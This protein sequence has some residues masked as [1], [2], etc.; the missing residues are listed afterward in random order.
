M[1]DARY[2]AA[3]NLILETLVVPPFGENTYLIGDAD[4]GVAIA[5]DPGGRADEL[6]ATAERRGVRIEHIINTHAHIDHVSGVEA[7]QALTGADFW[8]HP[9]AR[10]MLAGLTA[11]ARMFGLPD[12]QPPTVDHEI[13]VGR[14]I[15][16]GGLTLEVRFTPGHAPGHVTFVTPAVEYEGVVRPLALCGDVIFRG[17]IGR[18]DLPGGDTR[19]LMES[20]ER[21]I[22]SLSD[23]TVLLSGHG[24]ATSVGLERTGNPFVLDWLSRSSRHGA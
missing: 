22:L 24:P 13:E 20:I 19:T 12:L 14:P 3:M 4:A 8:L 1:T 7:L 9:D 15:A 18:T 21:E 5:V 17:S 16:V 11:Q 10:P 6:A 23:D 2:N